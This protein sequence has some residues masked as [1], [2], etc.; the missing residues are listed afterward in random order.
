MELSAVLQG[1]II[2]TLSADKSGRAHFEYEASWRDN[3]DAIPLSLSLPLAARTHPSRTV[4][5]VIWGLLPDNE[6]VLQAWGQ[7]FH[8][9][10]R[11]AVALLSQ[12]GEDCA[13][14][15]QFVKQENVHAVLNGEHDGIQWMADA[16][17]AQRLRALRL[18]ASASRRDSD[19]GQFSLP[20]AQPKI[21][22]LIDEGRW[23]IPAGRI[24]TTH[25][26]KPPT[27]A[28]E[29]YAQNEHYCLR[30]ASAVGLPT[31][32]SNVIQI[33]DEIA[34][35]VE[36]YDRVKHDG[37]WLRI[38][39]EDVC[40][41]LGVRPEFKYQNEGGPSPESI[42]RLLRDYSSDAG[43]DRNNFFLA[44]V[45]NWFIGGSDAHAKNY[46]LL[47]GAR[48]GVRLAPLYDISSAFPYGAIDRRKL[49]L[50]M[51]IGSNYRWHDIR[52]AD[53]LAQAETM[54]HSREDARN[55]LRIFVRDLPTLAVG[56]A[57]EVTRE[58]M[59]HPVI[60]RLVDDIAAAAEKCG[61]MLAAAEA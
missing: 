29:G 14:A 11:N 3:P 4:E 45:F 55:A 20:G 22:L 28:F 5:A 48:Q 23:G 57:E 13:G 56:V 17:L 58:G 61:R 37:T 31:C 24:P 39:Q 9:S 36:R 44:L 30:L 33:G 59:G 42:S 7:R 50:A 19:A 16:D 10:P 8:V 34:I 26:L 52:V 25:I 47:L 12:V 21:A 2:G 32:T 6:R 1:R 46:S 38:H 40:Q 49:K 54:G 60:T 35:C 41:A 43:E 15:I 53:W 51:K 18:D 27:G